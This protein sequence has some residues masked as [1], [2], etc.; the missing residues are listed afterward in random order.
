MSSNRIDPAEV[1]IRRFRIDDYD[2]LIE[3]WK[4]AQLPYKPNGRDSRDRIALE[5]THPNAVFLIAE[6]DGKIVGSIFGTHEGRKGWI[7]RLAIS[8]G[9]RRRGIAA[10]LVAKVEDHLSDLGID[11]VACLVEGWNMDSLEVFE[12]L[13]YTRHPD[14]FYFSKRKRADV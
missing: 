6:T 4:E 13:G 3:L 9:Y 7:N 14:I 8:P 2:P 11:I 5:I 10:T 12:K 1:K